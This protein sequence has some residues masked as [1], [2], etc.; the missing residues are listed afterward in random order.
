MPAAGLTEQDVGALLVQQDNSMSEVSGGCHFASN[1]AGAM[2]LSRH[3]NT[4]RS[5]TTTSAR[6][7]LPPGRV[8]HL[9]APPV[10]APA[11]STAARWPR[12]AASSG[13]LL[14]RCWC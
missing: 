5:A 13:S 1:L 8:W 10:R 9:L 7:S 12:A 4:L 14:A 2:A 11:A 3:P 6:S